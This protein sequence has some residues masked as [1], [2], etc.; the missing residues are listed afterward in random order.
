MNRKFISAA[1]SLLSFLFLAAGGELA[2]A[3]KL[4]P[5]SPWKMSK[6]KL[7]QTTQ[8]IALAQAMPNPVAVTTVRGDQA[9]YSFRVMK[10]LKGESTLQEISV[11]GRPVG[12]LRDRVTYGED[13]KLD[14]TFV[15]S[16]FY[17]VFLDSVHPDGY[18]EL[19]TVDHPW[20]KEVEKMLAEKPKAK[21]KKS[22]KGN[23]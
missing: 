19:S 23:S 21:R 1:I 10:V 15:P 5:S 22:A 13:C 16:K 18:R 14:V 20:V 2:S 17:L 4:E 7:V 8:T 9:N 12:S 11:L 3:C 6:E